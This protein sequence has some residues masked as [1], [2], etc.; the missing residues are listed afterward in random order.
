MGDSS[1][2]HDVDLFTSLHYREPSGA[3]LPNVTLAQLPGGVI[4]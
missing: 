3:P 4:G 2:A 1:A